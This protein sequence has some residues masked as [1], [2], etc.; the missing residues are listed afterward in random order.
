MRHYSKGE[1]QGDETIDTCV[2][3][4]S[5]N[6]L[7]VRDQLDFV[8]ALCHA[9]QDNIIHGTGKFDERIR[10]A[11]TA[12]W[13]RVMSRNL[14]IVMC[15]VEPD[16]ALTW[17]MSELHGR[18]ILRGFHELL[19]PAGLYPTEIAMLVISHTQRDNVITGSQGNFHWNHGKI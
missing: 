8:V 12:R 6:P 15:H 14:V 17:K 1:S 4:R 16:I 18:Y 11:G 10:E 7:F 5:Q 19:K 2:K 3:K 13:R 9:D